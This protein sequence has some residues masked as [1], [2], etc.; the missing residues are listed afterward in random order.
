MTI[1]A[2][3]PFRIVEG[4][5]LKNLLELLVLGFKSLVGGQFLEI[6]TKE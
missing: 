1:I 5:G 4:K 2:E 3:L 6:F